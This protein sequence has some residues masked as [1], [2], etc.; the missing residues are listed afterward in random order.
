MLSQCAEHSCH[1]LTAGLRDLLASSLSCLCLS[2]CL[3]S[4]SSSNPNGP[5]AVACCRRILFCHEEVLLEPGEVLLGSEKAL[6]ISGNPSLLNRLVDCLAA[7]LLCRSAVS[8]ASAYWEE[9]LFGHAVVSRHRLT[10][11]SFA[12]LFLP[13]P[14]VVPLLCCRAASA[15]SAYRRRVLLGHTMA[16]RCAQHS[17][18]Y[19]AACLQDLC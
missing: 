8:A 18:Y 1:H 10:A 5:A 6:L 14:L 19:P 13:C 4:L 9:V 11:Y 3:V 12:C 16:S 17:C 2:C 7:P 15:A